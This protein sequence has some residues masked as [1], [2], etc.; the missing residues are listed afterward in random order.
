[1]DVYSEIKGNE[2]MLRVFLSSEICF[3]ICMCLES[4]YIS[5]MDYSYYDLGQENI[6]QLVNIALEE[7][8]E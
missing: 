7:T 8:K 2:F 6:R 1:M 5:V 3:D 4:D